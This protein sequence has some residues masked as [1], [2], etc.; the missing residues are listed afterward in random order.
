MYV[1]DNGTQFVALEFK[2][3][4]GIWHVQTVSYHPLLNGLAEHA[5]QVFKQGIR[6]QSTGSIHDKIARLLFQYCITPH[7][8][9]GSNA[10]DRSLRYCLDLTDKQ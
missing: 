7:S 8:T 3:F 4:N 1:S 9:T 5:V 6:K 2:E 10:V